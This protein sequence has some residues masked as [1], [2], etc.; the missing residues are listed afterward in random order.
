MT[1]KETSKEDEEMC[2]RDCENKCKRET[3]VGDGERESGGE[4]AG[5]EQEGNLER[6]NPENE[7][8][9]AKNEGDLKDVQPNT[10]VTLDLTSQGLNKV[11]LAGQR[12]TSTGE[13]AKIRRD[14]TRIPTGKEG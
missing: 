1:E 3:M 4:N 6:N 12:C 2:L 14:D 13:W 11:K 9:S 8:R 10:Q 7:E 5:E